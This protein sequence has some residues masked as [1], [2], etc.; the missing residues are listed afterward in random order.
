MHSIE[1]VIHTI[2]I[3]IYIHH[4]V[5]CTI[6]HILFESESTIYIHRE[7]RLYILF[8]IFY[9]YNMI[10]IMYYIYNISFIT[11]HL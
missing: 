11:F 1:D 5:L 10:H 3:Y 4:T 7:Y 8:R 2:Y 9:I 6:Y